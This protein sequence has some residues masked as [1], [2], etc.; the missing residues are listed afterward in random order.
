MN[1]T[2]DQKCFT[3]SEVATYWHE[4][5]IPW[6]I[7]WSPIAGANK[8][9]D[10]D[11]ATD[12]PLPQSVTLGLHPIARKLL[13]ISCPA[14]GWEMSSSLPYYFIRFQPVYKEAEFA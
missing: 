11:A 3:T 8:Q 10:T 1:Q 7:T 14:K 4:L 2:C 6:C 13:L 12:T 5:M 9:L